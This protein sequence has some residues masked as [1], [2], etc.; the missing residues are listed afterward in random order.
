M[1]RKE[2]SPT[3]LPRSVR[4]E[5]VHYQQGLHQDAPGEFDVDF[6]PDGTPKVVCK[7]CGNS[8]EHP[9]VVRG[10]LR[11]FG[12]LPGDYPQ[13]AVLS[14]NCRYPDAPQHSR[15]PTQGVLTFQPL[16][17]PGHRKLFERFE[18]KAHSRPEAPTEAES[19]QPDVSTDA[20]T[21]IA[22]ATKWV[23]AAAGGVGAVLLAG[24]QLGG[25]STVDR[26][27][28]WFALGLAALALM[29]VGYSLWRSVS[30]LAPR[31]LPVA[32]LVRAKST[33]GTAEAAKKWLFSGFRGWLSRVP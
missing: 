12:Q 21:R 22:D 29:A 13:I 19:K 23:V 28:Q 25:L 7:T 5:Y 26:P 20:A 18:A 30:V 2:V 11:T 6:G 16:T 32:R 14:L 24:I 33:R 3:G 17:L 31:T 15:K 1:S 8:D 10:S 4:A 9:E 27:W